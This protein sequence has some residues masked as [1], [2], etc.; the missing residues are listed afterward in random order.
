MLFNF[1]EELVNSK[2]KELLKSSDCCNCKV[3]YEDICAIV[4][5]HTTPLYKRLDDTKDVEITANK[6]KKQLI[7]DIS[8]ETLKA[9]DIVKNNPRHT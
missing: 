2:V 3:C 7:M 1:S 8:I 9:I 6:S 5:N 4:L